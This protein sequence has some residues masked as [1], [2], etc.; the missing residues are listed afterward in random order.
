METCMFLCF[1]VE[2]YMEAQKHACFHVFAPF[3]TL[4]E[5]LAIDQ[6]WIDTCCDIYFVHSDV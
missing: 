6:L 3:S 1:Y 2:V 5:K 4:E